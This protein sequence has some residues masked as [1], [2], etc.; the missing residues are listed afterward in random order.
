MAKF[1]YRLTHWSNNAD[2]LN[3]LCSGQVGVDFV[4]NSTKEGYA[5]FTEGKLK[6]HYADKRRTCKPTKKCEV[7][8]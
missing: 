1:N 2:E 8:I 5:I 7:L 4:I 6:V 3:G